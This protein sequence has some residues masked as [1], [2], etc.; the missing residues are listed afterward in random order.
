M[1]IWGASSTRTC[2]P[3]VPDPYRAA[4]GSGLAGKTLTRTAWGEFPTALKLAVSSHPPLPAPPQT[5]SSH[6]SA[7]VLRLFPGSCSSLQAGTTGTFLLRSC[8]GLK[9][10]LLPG[11]C[12]VR[13]G[14]R[15]ARRAA[16]RLPG[17][18][19]SCRAACWGRSRSGTG[20]PACRPPRPRRI[21]H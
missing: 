5:V 1:V 10:R 4:G 16:Y 2:A 14:S 6:Q 19:T 11:C 12:L 15:K 20:V 7:A 17:P 9:L 3:A 8:S 13:S 18:V 21:C